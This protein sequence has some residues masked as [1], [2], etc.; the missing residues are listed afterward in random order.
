MGARVPWIE[1]RFTFDFPVGLWPDI[2]ERLRGVPARIEDRVRRCPAPILTRREANSWSI[3]ENI[4]HLLDLEPLGEKR[5][6]DFL[7]GK[8]V[9]RAADMTNRATNEAHHNERSITTLLGAFRAAREHLVTRLEG[10][11]DADFARTSLHPR[12]RQEL[13]L[14]DWMAFCAAHDDYHL[15]RMSELARLLGG[16]EA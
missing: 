7:A 11:A 6:D 3:Q 5:I 4:G 12:L 8:S 1:R 14:V 10:L 16:R 13:R 2:L 15:A 9:L